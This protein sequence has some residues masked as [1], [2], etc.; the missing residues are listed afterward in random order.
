MPALRYAL[1]TIVLFAA[2]T[3]A[4]DLADKIRSVTDASEY[5]AARWGIL[6]VN[7]ES[8]KTVYERNSDKLFLPASVTKLYTCA[9]AL[10]ELGPD[11]RFE[12][13]VYRRGEVKDKVLDGDL[14]LVARGDLTFGG[15]RGKGGTTL[16]CDNDHTYANSGSSNTQ[17]TDSDPLYALDDLAKQMAAGIQEVKGEVLIDDRMFARTRSSGSGPEVVCP[18]LVNDNVVDIIIRAG[19]KEGEPATVKTRPETGYVQMDADVRTGKEG[20]SPQV[21]IEATGSAQFTVRGRVPLK[22]A[23]VVRI[24]PVDEPNLWARALFIE[25]LRRNGVKVAASLHRP[26]RFDLPARDAR[27]PRVAE[28]KSEPLAEVVK[29]T[30]KVSHNLY[31]S[32]LPVLVGL[33]NGTGTAEAG[34]RQ[35][36]KLL[37]GFAVPPESVSFAGGAGGAQADSVTPRATV[38]LLRAMAK[39]PVAPEY[40][41]AL[42]ILGVDGTLAEAVPKDSPARGK[43]RAKTGTLSWYDAQ[44][45][46]PLLRSK[47]M[48]GEL[49]TAK[50][51]KLYFAMFLND[52][53]LPPS[54]TAAQQGKVLG[55]ICE[56]I[57]QYGP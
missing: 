54:G 29:V 28:Y 1:P 4:D 55:K 52:V 42:P 35:Q 40:F 13:P 9:T 26:R 22:C 27:L 10:C 30:L 47:A 53:P 46:R 15:R 21:T 39:H 34:L 14:I 23:P 33:Q 17:L 5:K 44:N 56:V 43:V 8:G 20:S 6:A 37:R 50:G 32:T 36:A 25:A 57:H 38:G 48:A 41:D 51:T 2:V 16:F 11:F 3:R 24:Y 19:A 18:I 49:E 12:T 31:A 7:C 45:E